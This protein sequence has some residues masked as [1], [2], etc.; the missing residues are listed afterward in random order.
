MS[1]YW[2]FGFRQLV[3]CTTDP[4][5]STGLGGYLLPSS[6]RA[7]VLF[8]TQVL[9]YFVFALRARSGVGKIIE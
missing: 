6:Y 4:C 7:L 2:E 9:F 1:D 5:S 8:F 3:V